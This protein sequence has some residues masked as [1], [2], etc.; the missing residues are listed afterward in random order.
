[1]RKN[2]V[3]DPLLYGADP[4]SVSGPRPLLVLNSEWYVA[5]RWHARTPVFE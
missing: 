2:L 5:R 1:M 3:I 4:R